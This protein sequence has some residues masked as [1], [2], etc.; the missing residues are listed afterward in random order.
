[1]KAFDEKY[2]N[3]ERWHYDSY[4][5]FASEFMLSKIDE[6]LKS[7]ERNLRINVGMLRQWLNEDVITDPSKLVE[8]EDL[9]SWLIKED[10]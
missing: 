9:L 3:V 8:N 10:K 2:P 1:M 4:V 7:Q 5:K 6:L